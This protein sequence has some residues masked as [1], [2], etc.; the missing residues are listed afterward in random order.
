MNKSELAQLIQNFRAGRATEHEKR[1]LEAYW[2]KAMEDTTPLNNLSPGEQEILKSEMFDSIKTQLQLK[3]GKP[4]SFY[5]TFYKVAAAI[6][7]LV[8]VSSVLY[9]NFP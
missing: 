4:V 5:R 9:F 8:A 7:L 1:R 3:V 2:D 6:L